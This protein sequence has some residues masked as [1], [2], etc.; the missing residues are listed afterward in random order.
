[1]KININFLIRLMM[2]QS[3][4]RE[5]PGFNLQFENKKPKTIEKYEF[6]SQKIKQRHNEHMNFVAY[7]LSNGGNTNK[8]QNYKFMSVMKVNV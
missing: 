7:N 5:K 2:P 1:M 4:K 8:D 6:V 3:N